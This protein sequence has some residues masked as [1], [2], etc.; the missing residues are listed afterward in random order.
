MAESQRGQVLAYLAL[1]LPLVLLPVAAYAIAAT[2]L[3]AQRGRFQ[4]A[5][6]QAAEDAVQQLDEQAFR[7]GGPAAPDGP[8]AVAAAR[9]DLFG[10][11]PA[12]VVDKAEVDGGQ[13][14]LAAHEQAPVP[15]AGFLPAAVVTLRVGVRARLAAGFGP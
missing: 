10:Y 3:D 8:A 9:A 2:T 5:I 7:A 6:S 13:L 15:L 4:A 14:V 11:E 1:V 12:A